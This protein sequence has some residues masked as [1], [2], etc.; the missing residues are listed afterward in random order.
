MLMQ[1]GRLGLPDYTALV[2]LGVLVGGMLVSLEIRRRRMP[3]LP[4]VDAAL[5]AGAAGILLG[6]ATYVATNWAYYADRIAEALRPWE[7]G[8]AWQ[9][10]LI[11]GV[12][13]AA[14]GSRLRRLPVSE[15]LDVLTPGAAALAAFGWLACHRAGCAWG[16]ET[17]PGQGLLWRLSLDLPDLYGIRE[18]RVAV[19][20]LGAGWSAL[21]LGG[22]VIA[23]RWLRKNG[24]VFALWVV[25]Q[26]LGSFGL[27]FLRGDQVPMMMDWRF[28]QLMNLLLVSGGMMIGVASLF[29]RAGKT[30]PDEGREDPESAV[31]EQER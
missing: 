11:G 31:S 2:R 25:F 24:T 6:R 30:I 28:D 15:V 21:L 17:Y 13:G 29:G 18:P 19:Q 1:F 9:G 26:S 10:A 3:W 12:V 20:L 14:T 4:M 23:G 16:I 27:G 7:G 5:A 8:L 22:V